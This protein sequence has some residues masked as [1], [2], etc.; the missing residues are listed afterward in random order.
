L[1]QVYDL[2]TV[3]KGNGEY[4]NSINLQRRNPI[5]KKKFTPTLCKFC[6][7]KQISSKG[8]KKYWTSINPLHGHCSFDHRN[9]NYKS[10]L[11]ELVNDIFHG[12]LK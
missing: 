7:E 3:G 11:L 6:E 5:N 9:E 10:Y 2:K 4:H 1:S 12:R 8:R